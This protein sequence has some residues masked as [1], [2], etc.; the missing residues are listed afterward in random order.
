VLSYTYNK[1]YKIVKNSLSNET[2]VLYQCGAPRPTVPEATHFFTVPVTKVAISDTTPVTY[3]ELLGVRSSI[4]MTTGGVAY[5]T[6]PC[7]Q[8]QTNTSNAVV[9]VDTKVEATGLAQLASVDVVFAYFD[10]FSAK[11]NNTV[12][13]P[14]S[15]DPGAVR[16]SFFFLTNLEKR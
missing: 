16:V 10:S 3:L 4:K 7:I 9:D 14:A 13:F 6:S 8:A 11:S 1:S 5:I 15:S 12:S 2:I